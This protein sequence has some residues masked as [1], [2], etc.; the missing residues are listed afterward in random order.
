MSFIACL[1]YANHRLC[2]PLWRHVPARWKCLLLIFPLTLYFLVSHSSYVTSRVWV[3]Q[4]SSCETRHLIDHSE[5][6]IYHKRF[7]QYNGLSVRIRP[8]TLNTN[9]AISGNHFYRF[10]GKR[11]SSHFTKT[12][13]SFFCIKTFLYG[14]LTFTKTRMMLYSR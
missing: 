14:V 11:V 12:G 6:H 13:F 7:V 4:R 9:K 3:N 2:L 1:F 8:L 5:N 10:D